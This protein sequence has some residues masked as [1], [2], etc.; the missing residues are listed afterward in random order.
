MPTTVITGARTGLGLEHVRQLS[1]D[2]SNTVFALVRSLTSGDLTAL[3]T[4]QSSAAATIHILE[5]D[6]SSPPSIAALPA[7]ITGTSPTPVVINVLINNAAILHHKT[8]TSLTLTPSAFHS[9][10]AT[11]VLGPALTL[12]ALL[13]MLAPDARVVNVTSGL[14]S[15]ELLS[16]GTI[17]VEA[18]HY[19]V[20]KAALNMLTVHQARQVPR[21]VVVVCVD[22]GHAKTEMGGAGATT[23]PAESVAGIWRVVRGLRGED[24][25]RFFV[26]SGEGVP[27]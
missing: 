14:G 8:E 5:C 22:P 11:N 25:G 7:L 18:T 4:I 3:R 2:P 23:E 1:L 24:S 12:A 6:T 21:G 27:W 19:S 16:N 10:M 15:L 9:H 17:A 20:S 26:F 13:P